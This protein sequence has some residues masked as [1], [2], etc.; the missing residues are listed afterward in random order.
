MDVTDGISTSVCSPERVKPAA[1]F[2][3][4]RPSGGH[5]CARPQEHHQAPASSTSLFCLDRG[6]AQCNICSLSISKL[7]FEQFTFCAKYFFPTS[8]FSGSNF[9]YSSGESQPNRHTRIVV[10]LTAETEINVQ[11]VSRRERK[12]LVPPRQTQDVIPRGSTPRR[13]TLYDGN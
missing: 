12:W 2:P 13:P 8:L 1:V 11:R 3:H 10:V 9:H 5:H 4:S 7:H 6:S